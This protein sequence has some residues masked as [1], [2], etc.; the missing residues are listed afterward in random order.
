MARRRRRRSLME[1]SSR[2]DSKPESSPATKTRGETVMIARW[3]AAEWQRVSCCSASARRVD[4]LTRCFQIWATPRSWRFTASSSRPP[5][6][7]AGLPP[8]PRGSAPALHGPNGMPGTRCASVLN[9]VLLVTRSIT[10][11]LLG[12]ERQAGPALYI[13]GSHRAA[14]RQPL[15]AAAAG[16]LPHLQL[17]GAWPEPRAGHGEVRH[18]GGGARR[19]PERRG[20]PGPLQHRRGRG[21]EPRRA[22]R[23]TTAGPGAPTACRHGSG[24]AQG[25]GRVLVVPSW[26]RR[27]WARH[28]SPPMPA[29]AGSA[30][31]PQL[32]LGGRL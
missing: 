9:A 1:Q 13:R 5:I 10:P 8:P 11:P 3:A 19:I 7:M 6:L 4:V 15:S 17:P 28:S 24:A 21:R 29:E 23:H 25:A 27:S 20:R 16:Q 32:P 30:L 14:Q 31:L 26:Q 2:P 18:D 12:G 22:P